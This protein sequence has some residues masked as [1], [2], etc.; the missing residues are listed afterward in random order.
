MNKTTEET[1]TVDRS[2]KTTQELEE[3][4]AIENSIVQK[5]LYVH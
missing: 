4:K 3:I 1:R 2:V 5:T